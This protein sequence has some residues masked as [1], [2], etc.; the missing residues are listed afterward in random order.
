[1]PNQ[2]GDLRPYLIQV[3]NPLGMVEGTGFLCHPEGYALTCWHVV[4][5]WLQNAGRRKGEVMY[6][7]ERVSTELIVERSARLADVAVL[8]LIPPDSKRDNSSSSYLPLDVHW[9]VALNDTLRSFGYP[10]GQFGIS[11][12]PIV[13]KL[14][15]LE[16]LAV[17]GVEVLPISG[18]NLDN[19]DG[20]YSGAPVVNQRTQ[21]VI[22]LVRAKHHDTQAFIV[23]LASL[24]GAWPEL[25]ATH[26][27]FEQIRRRLGDHAQAKLA[28]KLH[29]APFIS[30]NLEAGVMPEAVERRDKAKSGSD[31]RQHA[32]GRQWESFDLERLLPPT[33]SFVLSSDVGTGKTT[34]LFWLASELVQQSDFVPLVMSCEELERVNPKGLEGLLEVL[35]SQLGHEFPEFLPVDLEAFVSQAAKKDRLV[36]LFDGLDQ[37]SS[38]K[39][40]LLARLALSIA[41]RYPLVL[42]SRPSA[43]LGIENDPKLVLLRLQPFSIQDQQ[44]YFGEHYAQAQDSVCAR[45]RRHAATDACLHG[46]RAPSG[47]GN[48]NG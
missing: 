48:Q 24:F 4:E 25:V 15:G 7:G 2:L 10:M 19:V 40:T 37:I 47:G 9:R 38:G 33:S 13:G 32:P 8:R 26:D 30:L 45:P 22:G 14:G 1:M 41:G 29:A 43:V 36:L 34:F 6:H 31:A 20:G 39:P 42:T 21:K 16:P 44:R 18:L 12:I 35:T 5:P 17:D 46:A 27:V 3:L 11:G 23:P 28:E